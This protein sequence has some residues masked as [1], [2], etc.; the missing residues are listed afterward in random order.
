MRKSKTTTTQKPLKL[1]DLFENKGTIIA[2][3]QAIHDLIEYLTGLTTPTLIS[4]N[5]ETE[6]D[7]STFS[8]LVGMTAE[9]RLERELVILRKSKGKGKYKGADFDEA[10]DK[11]IASKEKSLTDGVGNN[12]AY[13]QKGLYTHVEGENSSVKVN[14]TNGTVVV[15]G[16][17]IKKTINAKF[18]D[19]TPTNHRTAVTRAKA[20]I[21]RGLCYKFVTLK[22]A[23]ESIHSISFNGNRLSLAG[24]KRIQEVKK[25]QKKLKRPLT[26][27]ERDDI[28]SRFQP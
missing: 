8:I 15:S 28:Y 11:L 5:Y 2:N 1:Q 9:S 4:L 19:R 21:E 17:V 16:I 27:T 7:Q 10:F 26:K 18:K 22:I 14:N 3:N 12:P 13:T 6:Y 25:M 20:I 24:D 23:P